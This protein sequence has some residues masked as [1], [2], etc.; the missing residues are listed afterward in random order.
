MTR[1][2]LSL[3]IAT[4]SGCWTGGTA[5]RPT[6]PDTTASTPSEVA[7]ER[8]PAAEQEE[9][10]PDPGF[11][12]ATAVADATPAV[13]TA[14]ASPPA[15]AASTTETAPAPV[16]A[17]AAS[18]A[19]Y[20]T[21]GALYLPIDDGYL[22]ANA[23]AGKRFLYGANEGRIGARLSYGSSPYSQVFAVLVG[24][25]QL[26]WWGAFGMGIGADLGVVT[27]SEK[28]GGGWDGTT[29][30]GTLTA[31]FR[32]RFVRTDLSFDLGLIYAAGQDDPSAPFALISV[33][34]PL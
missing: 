9:R 33:M 2:L 29:F 4:C 17:P 16:P 28:M 25:M 31:T 15:P 23:G 7:N 1:T 18:W 5:A 22:A 8:S 27:A 20:V 3:L 13:A 12:P 11:T 19:T 26:H 34:A 6:T 14:P 21:A 24:G 30:G 10:R 32:H